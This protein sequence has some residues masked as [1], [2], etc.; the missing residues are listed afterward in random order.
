MFE[1]DPKIQNGQKIPE[2][3]DARSGLHVPFYIVPDYGKHWGKMTSVF[4]CVDQFQFI[5][6]SIGKIR[7]NQ[8]CKSGLVGARTNWFRKLDYFHSFFSAYTWYHTV[9]VMPQLKTQIIFENL[10]METMIII[11]RW[12]PAN[13]KQWT[14]FLTVLNQCCRFQSYLENIWR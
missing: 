3:L 13:S 2:R 8:S 12:V 4:F 10:E 5:D 7:C 11:A 9:V 6:S 14:P 1:T